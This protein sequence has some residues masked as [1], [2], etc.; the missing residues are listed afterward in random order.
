[1]HRPLWKTS[2]ALTLSLSLLQPGHLAAQASPALEACR[3]DPDG[4]GC[5]ALLLQAGICDADPGLEGCAELLGLDPAPEIMPELVPEPDPEPVPE[6]E[7]LAA[8]PEALPS[9]IAD[10]APEAAPVEDAPP[11]PA[12]Q[13]LAAP[14]PA[15]EPDSPDPAP[16]PAPPPEAAPPMPAPEPVTEIAPELVPAE[17]PMASGTFAPP[18]EPAPK[19]TVEEAAVLEVLTATP[20]VAEALDTLDRALGSQA[21]P[22]LVAAD[23]AGDDVGAE[24]VAPALPAAAALPEATAPATEVEV[25]ARV[26]TEE[27]SRG[28]D[29]EFTSTISTSAPR[30]ARRDR[31]M[32]DLERAGLVAL[33]T[34]AVGMIVANNRVVAS[35]DDRVVVDRGGGD[36]AVWR[37]DDAILRRPGVTERIERFADG[38]TITTIDRPDGTRLVTI[39][40]ATGRTL[41]RE[42]VEH[43]GSRMQIFDDTRP[44]EPVEVSILPAPQVAELRLRPGT[45]PALFRAILAEI[46]RQPIGRTFSL[47]QVREIREVRDLAAEI[48]TDP[49]LFE[50][51]SA[52]V[53]PTEAAKLVDLARVMTAL[54]AENP[55]E[56][57]L[58]EGHTDATGSAA[59]NLA[60]SDRRAESVALA[61]TQF[62]GVPPENMVVQGYG[63]RFLKVPTLQ[64]EPLNRRVALRRITRL[65]H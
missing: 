43:D 11:E 14:A 4:E 48:T 40:D 45:D 60:L 44:F 56:L 10:P 35:S 25:T 41:R 17:A 31:G 37:D 24:A 20:E 50:T 53:R 62:F 33:G 2:T 22:A 65:I 49:I 27:T 19:P 12:P 18:P 26:V 46:D 51:A 63:K 36:L 1:M 52:M 7:P 32:S 3:A 9:G 8:E 55:R 57:F 6:P 39:R 58:V 15:P 29:E 30:E 61:L 5:D 42:R 23:T 34:L 64:A 59:F 21:R 13:P 47:A 54:I 16:E 38:S 28:A